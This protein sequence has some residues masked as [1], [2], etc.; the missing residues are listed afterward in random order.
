[1]SILNNLLRLIIVLFFLTA[2]TTVKKPLIEAELAAPAEQDTVS[3]QPEPTLAEPALVESDDIAGSEAPARPI[4]PNQQLYLQA[5]DALKQGQTKL[6]I[7]ILEQLVGDASD[8][9]FVFTNLG[10]AYFNLADLELAETAFQSAINI[11]EN[12]FV[13]YN[14]L[15][16]LLRKKGEFAQALDN[17]QQ[18]IRSNEKYAQAYLNLGILYDLYLQD[19]EKAVVQYEKYLALNGVE[20][21][22]V[23]G[24][25]VDIKRRMKSSASSAQE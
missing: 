18:A 1:M 6:A 21:K 19:L 9:P 11:D 4:D 22:Q 20:D 3:D 5:I 25:I 17:Y 10:L 24:W 2:C 12:D 7:E 16:I 14:H 23:S 13:A 15:G 8:K